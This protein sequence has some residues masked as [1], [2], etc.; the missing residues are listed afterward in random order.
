M[1]WTFL[2]FI[3]FSSLL[4][5]GDLGFSPI[6]FKTSMEWKRSP[7]EED[8][9]KD[10]FVQKAEKNFIDFC[11]KFERSVGVDYNTLPLDYSIPPI[12]HFIWLGSPVPYT[13]QISIESW[14]KFHPDWEIKVW[15]DEEVKKFSWTNSH[16][17]FV[18]EQADSWAEKAD[19]LR[20][21]ILYQ[22]GGIY[23]DVDVLCLKSFH[24]LIIQKITFFS[25]FELNYVSSHYGEAFYIG[26]AIMGA[27]KGSSLMKKCLENCKSKY[28]DP[29]EG[30][31][32]RTGP[33]LMSKMCKIAFEDPEERILILPCGYLYPWPWK[34]RHE[35]YRDFIS[36][37]SM[38]IHLWS[39][40]WM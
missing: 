23:S 28:E 26:T 32:K 37:H 8:F 21:D 4:Q 15:T 13:V 38:A 14:K 36:P 1:K 17:R 30:I 22:F 18:F 40:S 2:V 3:I 33:G 12:L 9:Q 10:Y 20:L 6:S 7:L 27:S 25:S 16:A 19:V 39:N 5:G 34:K 29:K 24:D 11:E 35:N 31:L